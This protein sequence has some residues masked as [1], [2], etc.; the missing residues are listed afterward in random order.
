M[1]TM[2]EVIG[3]LKTAAA[4]EA[5]QRAGELNM[6]VLRVQEQLLKEAGNQK[7]VMGMAG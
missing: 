7:R 1:E 5:R 3:L 2:G 4:E 6:L